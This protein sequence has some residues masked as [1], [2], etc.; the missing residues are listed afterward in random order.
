[1]RDRVLHHAVFSVINPMFEPTF[2]STSFSCRIGYGTHR[3][4]ATLDNMM[5][6]VSQNNT[7]PCYVLKC[8]IKK[9]FDS[10]DHNTLLSILGR[11]IRDEDVMW[12]LEEII[13]SFPRGLP[14]GN[15]TSQIFAN[16][17]MNEFDQ[18]VKHELKVK[19]YVRYTDDFAIVSDN[20]YTLRGGGL[21]SMGKF[22]RERLKLTIHPKKISLRK[23]HQGVDFLGYVIFPKHRLL[24]IKT[25]RRIFSKLR[26]RIEE[27]R[28]GEA[29]QPQVEQSLQSYLGVLSHA[30]AYK[31]SQDLRNQLWLTDLTRC[32]EKI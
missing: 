23:L 2:I 14:I 29:S 30:N 7:Q 16:I 18:F 24:R 20:E 32:L 13:E 9:F 17:Y 22:L 19:Y 15:L 25:K 31:L 8:D 12:L 21:T 5:R 6:K 26:K 1:M 28:R 27:Y 3:G 11:R 4:V 10:V